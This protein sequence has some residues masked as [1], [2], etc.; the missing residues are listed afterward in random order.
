MKILGV[1]PCR[2]NASRLPGKPLLKLLGRPLIQHVYEGVQTS[3]KID[4]FIVATDSQNIIDCV[5]SFGGQAVLTSSSHNTGTERVAEVAEKLAEYDIILNIQGDEPLVT[6]EMVDQLATPL[7]E[8]PGIHMTALKG[9]ITNQEEL[10]DPSIIKVVTDKNDCAIYFSRHPIP[11]PRN[12]TD[13]Y[14]RNKGV[15]GF[16]RSFILEFKDLPRGPLE[17]AESLEQLRAIEYGKQIF[18]SETKTETH[19]VNTPED[20]PIVEKALRSKQL[21]NG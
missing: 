6:G 7:V 11:Y 8:N 17:L 20:I 10:H 16:R 4:Q 2:M 13:H 19:G 15:Y 1:I 9:R 12:R 14:Y 21:S 5:R 18:V 3:K